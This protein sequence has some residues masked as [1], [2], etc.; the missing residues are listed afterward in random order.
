MLLVQSQ[1]IDFST[2]TDR[3][4]HV[5]AGGGLR[6]TGQDETGKRLQ[7]FR[8]VVYQPFQP[9]DVLRRDAGWQQVFLVGRRQR[10]AQIGTQVEQQ[11]LEWFDDIGDGGGR[12]GG[13]CQS[14]AAAG[15]IDGTAGCNSGIQFGDTRTISEAGFPGITSACVD[16][17]EPDHG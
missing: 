8:E 2:A 5:Q 4:G 6:S 16:S 11:L 12:T 14:E 13:E 7:L 3:A 10:H 15:F 1:C 17:I 9:G